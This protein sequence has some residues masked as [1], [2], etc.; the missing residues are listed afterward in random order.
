MEMERRE[1]LKVFMEGY[2]VYE[3]H[4]KI[5]LVKIIALLSM[6]TMQL[7]L[8]RNLSI[9]RFGEFSIILSVTTVASVLCIWGAIEF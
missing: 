4:V 8:A 5:L 7:V 3:S 2:R 9:E 1:L 6:F